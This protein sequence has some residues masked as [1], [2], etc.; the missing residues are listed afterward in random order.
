MK[1]VK[2]QMS[3]S[4]PRGEW[5]GVIRAFPWQIYLTLFTVFFRI[6][7]SAWSASMNAVKA[8]SVV[9]L[10]Q[11]LLFTSIPLSIEVLLKR[12]V[13]WLPQWKFYAIYFLFFATNRYLLVNC[14]YGTVF[15]QN[16]DAMDRSRRRLL[17][18]TSLVIAVGGFAFSA[19]IAGKC[20]ELGR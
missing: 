10:I 19:Y 1:I 14:R 13:L 9:T 20:A 17:I 3:S 7:R 15:E 18:A 12:R 8:V 6:G 11:C 4:E 2:R 5:L 16:F